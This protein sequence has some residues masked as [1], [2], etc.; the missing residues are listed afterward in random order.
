MPNSA[1]KY[2]VSN[3]RNVEVLFEVGEK[4]KAI[5]L[6]TV[7]GK[8]M[9]EAAGYYLAKREYGNDLNYSVIILGEL[10]R[11]LYKYGEADL[12]KKYEDAYQKYAEILQMNDR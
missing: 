5:E 3:A 10:Q 2:D 7:L 11:V 4:E 1:I 6:A 9:D 12:A 8:Q